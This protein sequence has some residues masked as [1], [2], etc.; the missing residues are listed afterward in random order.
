MN[1]KN[2]SY[3]EVKPTLI[4]HTTMERILF[5]GVH[6]NYKITP[7]KGYKIHVKGRDDDSEDPV[8]GVKN[9]KLGYTEGVVTCPASYNFEENPQELYAVL[10]EENEE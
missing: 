1:H 5:D 8:T 4:E 3:D 7:D 2:I 6:Q 9:H 10:K